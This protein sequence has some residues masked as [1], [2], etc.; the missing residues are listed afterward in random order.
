MPGYLLIGEPDSL[1]P[2]NH[3]FCSSC[4]KG[5]MTYG[6]GT[7]LYGTVCMICSTRATKLI[8]FS[9]P[10]ALPGDDIVDLSDAKIITSPPFQGPSGFHSVYELNA[11][12][13]IENKGHH[14]IQE[15]SA[16]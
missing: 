9:A 4:I 16:W 11:V 5:S 8:G 3:A 6:Y 13:D 7:N 14:E 2:C 1:R 10:M 12:P 15:M